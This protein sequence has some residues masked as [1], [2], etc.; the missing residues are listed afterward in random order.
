MV[1]RSLA[2]SGTMSDQAAAMVTGGFLSRAD[3]GSG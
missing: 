1:F 3:A 2:G